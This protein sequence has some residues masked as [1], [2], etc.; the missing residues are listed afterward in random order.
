MYETIM[1][2]NYRKAFQTVVI[3]AVLL[4]IASAIAVPLSLSQQISDLSVL[5][6]SRVKATAP[7]TQI[8]RPLGRAASRRSPQSLML[9]S[10]AAPSCGWRCWSTTGC[11]L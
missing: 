8:E 3:L 5:A 7:A 6:Q 1:K 2:K 10:V 11:W 4:V 9:F